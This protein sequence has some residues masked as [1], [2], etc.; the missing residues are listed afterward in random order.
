M[1]VW[2]VLVCFICLVLP[3]F[4][5]LPPPKV[6]DS[7]TFSEWQEHQEFFK[8]NG[9][10]WIKNFFST[11]QVLLLRNWADEVNEAAESLLALAQATGQ[12]IGH[13]SQSI[14]GTL[15]VVPES[16]NPLQVCRAEDM[17]SCY[18]DLHFFIAGTITSYLHSL[19][20]EPYVLFKDKINFKW[21]G[22][23]A[24]LPHQDFPAYDLFGPREHVTAM[25]CIDPA[26]LE[27]GC[28]HVAKHWRSTFADDSSI[29][30]ESLRKGRAILPYIVGGSA[31]GSIQPKYHEKIAWL[32]LETSP[33]DLVLINSYLPHYSEPNQSTLPRRAMFFTHNR[34]KEGEHRKAYYHAK[35]QD[36]ENPAF[37]FATPTKARTK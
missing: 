1:K 15:V 27:N 6:A 34:L 4:G 24:F 26:T 17:L 36:P 25:V 11:D 18:P 14:P 33:G 16:R 10:L 8:E 5:F 28:L 37:H 30:A 12:S 9:Y 19:L 29:D 3:C 22:G 21:P 20:G 13:F 31:H 23:G 32:A 35:R 2:T 7:S